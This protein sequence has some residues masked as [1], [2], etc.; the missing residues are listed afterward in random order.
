MK[1]V[2]AAFNQEKALVG[3]FSVITN[4][5]I[6]FGWNFLKHYLLLGYAYHLV[7]SPEY[8]N[9]SVVAAGDKFPG[10]HTRHVD[11]FPG[12]GRH[13]DTCPGQ[14]RH[15]VCAVREEAGAGDAVLDIS[16]E[17]HSEHSSTEHSKGTASR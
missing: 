4:L 7:R 17:T 11:T 15:V 12:R 10:H 1:A 9:I 13:G 3:A 16:V 14:G 2:V 5:R 6:C 8:A